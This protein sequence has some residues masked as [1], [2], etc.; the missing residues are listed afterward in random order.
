MNKKNLILGFGQ[1]GT[2]IAKYLHKLGVPFE[3]MDSRKDLKGI[4]WL[5]DRGYK[6]TSE[7]N[8]DSLEKISKIYVSPGIPKNNPI[9]EH[10]NLLHVEIETDIDVFLKL[11]SC[12]KILITGTNGKTTVTS[13]SHKLFSHFLDKKR[14]EAIGNIG[15]PVLDN[16]DEAIDIALIELSS[17]QLELSSSLS[18]DIAVLLNV[19]QDHLDRHSSFEEYKGIKNKVFTESKLAIREGQ[20]HSS[21]EKC[22]YFQ[23]IFKDYDYYF[24]DLKDEWP[25]HDVDNIKA[26]ISIL[27]AY[28]VLNQEI[29]FYDKPQ[30]ESFIKDCLRILNSFQRLPH[31]YEILDLK[32]GVTF[33]NDSKATNVASVLKALESVYD[34][35]GEG[36]AILICGGDSKGQDFQEL[37]N[38]PENLLKK[39]YIFGRHKNLIA[40]YLIN[41]GV[42]LVE[43]MQEAMKRV[44]SDVI[45]GD[46]VI[47]S[48]ACSSTDMYKDYEER[49]EEF[50]SLVGS[51]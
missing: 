12:A 19:T 47:L 39:A 3:V 29:N 21:T 25:L 31:R 16:I 5:T 17:Y 36:K 1:T 50:R 24:D 15:N 23:E 2:S 46:V 18:S 43:D 13:M 10:A 45:K 6:C 20:S 7:F 38:I 9:L 32:D 30:R 42:E 33:I 35:Y 26:T 37:L 8:V 27:Y 11:H 14:V 41:T 48:P 51:I 34:K 44:T 28:L 40:P 4:Q 49:G 22:I